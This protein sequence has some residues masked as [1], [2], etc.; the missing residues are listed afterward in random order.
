MYRSECATGCMFEDKG[1]KR[2]EERVLPECA[3]YS[4]RLGEDSDEYSPWSSVKSIATGASSSRGRGG[5]GRGTRPP[6]YIHP[7][8]A[9]GADSTGPFSDKT[10]GRLNHALEEGEGEGVSRDGFGR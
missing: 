7:W 1:K 10:C 6:R 8:M 3:R 2:R 9:V 4:D 5:L